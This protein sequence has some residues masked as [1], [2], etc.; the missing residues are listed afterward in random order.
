M[1]YKPY[2]RLYFI[3]NKTGTRTSTAA[4]TVKN[5]YN[6][7]HFIIL[8]KNF[9]SLFI[10]RIMRPL[11]TVSIFDF[12]HCRMIHY[13]Y[14]LLRISELYD[15]TATWCNRETLEILDTRIFSF[16][17]HEYRAFFEHGI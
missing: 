17:R 11:D 10:K 8:I 13:T 6:S 1:D 7:G 14:H 4:L 9:N 15:E 12:L 3:V 2:T 16:F 5:A